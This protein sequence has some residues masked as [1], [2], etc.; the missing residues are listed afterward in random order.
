MGVPMKIKRIFDVFFNEGLHTFRYLVKDNINEK[1]SL[2]NKWKAFFEA[3]DN[4]E[5]F[6]YGKGNLKS[7]I[8]IWAL[9]EK[10]EADSLIQKSVKSIEE[11]KMKTEYIVITDESDLE[12]AISCLQWDYAG[13]LAVGDVLRPNYCMAICDMV[14]FSRENSNKS[15]LICY[16]YGVIDTTFKEDS[17][18]PEFLPE[19]SPDYLL[20]Y[21]YIGDNFVVDMSFLREIIGTLSG[22]GQFFSYQLLLGALF[23]INENEI[24]HIPEILK[25]HME[26]YR[27]QDEYEKK[28]LRQLKKQYLQNENQSVEIVAD[29]KTGTEHIYYIPHK[30]PKVSIIIPSKDNPKLVEQC[31]ESISKC[32]KYTPYEVVFV[33]NGSNSQN[34]EW[35]RDIFEKYGQHDIKY[36]YEKMEFNFSKMCNIGVKASNGEYLL[37]L[38]DDI[39]VINK[40]FACERPIDWLGVL[41]GQAMQPY[42]GAV[43]AKLYYPDSEIIQHVGLINY[44]SGAAHI[45]S[46]EEDSRITTNHGV[47]DRNYIAVTG[48]CLAVSREKFNLAGGF[49]EDLAVTF[50]DVDLCMKLYEN[51]L[52]NIVRKDV[53]LYHHESIT[54]GNDAVDKSKFRRH[55]NERE[56]L[57]DF[58]KQLVKRDP[59]YSPY[60]TQNRLDGSINSH[61]YVNR[62]AKSINYNK[63]NKVSS[64]KE[65]GKIH[66]VFIE[67]NYMHIRGYGFKTGD[68]ANAVYKPC[69][70]IKYNGK[71]FLYETHSLYEPTLGI[72]LGTGQNVNFASFYA[73]INMKE[74][75]ENLDFSGCEIHIALYDGKRNC[76][77]TDHKFDWENN[78]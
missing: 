50:N 25:I 64:M 10:K 23:L 4:M 36:I 6:T 32:T 2:Q 37:F 78:R 63:I 57:F 75:G 52:H 1:R 20:N 62:F 38:N 69:I 29:F 40:E 19:F 56:K 9:G 46:K 26:T 65:K 13:F 73:C 71:E 74:L 16:D 44:E 47:I 14:H 54:R 33:D 12:E 42:T 68:R 27:Q 28:F 53:V 8:I 30:M 22:K 24:S 72:Y 66:S 48:A 31:L 58:H 59:Y 18:R 21:D 67:N 55:L 11:Q 77:I 51:G 41:I 61:Y 45:H 5:Y 43:G 60:L 3:Y 76:Y 7:G 17:V 15:R 35:Y 39:E 34:Q 70:Y 49:T